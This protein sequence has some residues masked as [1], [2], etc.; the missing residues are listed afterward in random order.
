MKYFNLY[1]IKTGNRINKAP[2][3]G[4]I[5]SKIYEDGCVKKNIKGAISRIPLNRIRMVEVKIIR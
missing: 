4:N 1:D 5:I 2:V 3:D